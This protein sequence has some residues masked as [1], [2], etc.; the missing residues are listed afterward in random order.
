MKEA[1]SLPDKAPPEAG[2]KKDA[3]PAVKPNGQK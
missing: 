2:P 3:N 1:A